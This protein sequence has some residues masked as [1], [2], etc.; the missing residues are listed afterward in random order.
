MAS[1]AFAA[2]AAPSQT[3]S[4]ITAVYLTKN[5]AYEFQSLLKSSLAN[6]KKELTKFQQDKEELQ[7]KLLSYESKI[8]QEQ[9]D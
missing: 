3:A 7:T 9:D 6:V 5:V 8:M 4:S 1:I 2:T